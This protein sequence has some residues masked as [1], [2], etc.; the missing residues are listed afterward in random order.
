MAT[1]GATAD[2]SV[3]SGAAGGAIGGVGAGGAPAK[4]LSAGGAPFG[5]A[6]KGGAGVGNYAGI[7]A[8]PKGPVNPVPDPDLDNAADSV[9]APFECFGKIVNGCRSVFFFT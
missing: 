6:P 8:R 4:G 7:G 2:G 1:K 5:A 3:L 9:M